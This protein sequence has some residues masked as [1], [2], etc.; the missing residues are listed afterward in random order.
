ME[1]QENVENQTPKPLF[2]TGNNGEG[3]RILHY[4]FSRILNKY[5]RTTCV[6]PE[7]MLKAARTCVSAKHTS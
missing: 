2:Q 3:I 1:S 6:L 7:H 4:P 5:I